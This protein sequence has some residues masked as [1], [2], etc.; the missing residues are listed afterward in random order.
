MNV[1]TIRLELTNACN[2][3][4]LHCLRDKASAPAFL[5][6]KTIQHITRQARS[7][8][9]RE[10]GL[11]GG[12]PTLHPRFGDILRLLYRSGYSFSLFTNGTDFSRVYRKVLP[13]KKRLKDI[14]FSLDG[15]TE[16]THD[17]T[18]GKGS[19][20]QVLEAISICRRHGLDY[21]LN[22]VITS[23]NRHEL[24]AIADLAYRLGCQNLFF[25]HVQPTRQVEAR[26]LGLPIRACRSADRTIAMLGK[27]YAARLRIYLCVGSFAANPFYI[28]RIPL[29]SLTLDCRG[30]IIY[31]I[32]LA[33]L[34]FHLSGREIISS[35]R[36]P[37]LRDAYGRIRQTYLALNTQKLKDAI[38]N[39]FLGADHFPCRYC[40][41]YFRST[42]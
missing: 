19:Y 28:C 7:C 9:V 23:C 38:G 16:A 41:R 31:C 6:F 37:D 17:K 21:S 22:T 25:A 30:N 36:P 1:P 11:T 15:A 33:S 39:R 32:L 13:Y 40:M 20:R 29:R 3:R 5:P 42:G 34:D 10:F 27:K 12:E 8:G 4:C 26:R 35:R 18:R 24:S 14:R 2:L